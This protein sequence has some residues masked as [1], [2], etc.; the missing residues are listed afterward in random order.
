MA[1]A[2]AGRDRDDPCLLCR[3]GDAPDPDGV[4]GSGRDPHSRP[5][6]KGRGLYGRRLR[7]HR[8]ETGSV[9]GPV[10]RRRQSRFR[11]AGPLSRA[12]PGGR[13]DRAQGA[14]VPASQQLSGNR[15]RPAVRGGD[16]VFEPGRFDRRIAAPAAPCLARGI[17]RHPAADSSRFLRPAGRRHRTRPNQR[18]DG[19]RS[20]GAAHSGASAGRRRERHR[21]RCRGIDR[22]STRRDRC[23]RRGLGLAS[24]AGGARSGRGAG[25]ADRDHARR[26]RL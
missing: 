2:G 8:R 21:A 23:R 3:I 6:R 18:A 22:G 16:Q 9:H 12:Q 1:G 13:I 11:I 14:V 10:G 15:P 25:G 20:R 26:P 5:F 4:R 17:G 7:P 19:H 24:R